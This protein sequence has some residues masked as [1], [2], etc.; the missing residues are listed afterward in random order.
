M[1]LRR[2]RLGCKAFSLEQ[3]FAVIVD[4]SNTCS[5]KAAFSGAVEKVWILTFISLTH[6][7]SL[8]TTFGYKVYVKAI[9]EYKVLTIQMRYMRF[10]VIF[11]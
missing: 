5:F 3:E 2:A 10:I 7:H 11:L 8:R 1:T 9:I 6:I 4:K